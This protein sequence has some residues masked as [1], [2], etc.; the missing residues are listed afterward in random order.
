MHS[1]ETLIRRQGL[2]LFFRMK[3]N[4]PTGLGIDWF[5]E[6]LME[7]S[8][9]NEHF[10][11][12]SFRFI[13]ALPVL[14]TSKQI[15]EHLKAYFCNSNS[16]LPDWVSFIT[17]LIPTHGLYAGLVSKMVFLLAT[18]MASKF[19]AGSNLAEME[20]RI[21]K[22]RKA[23]LGFT[24]DILG[25][26][27]ITNAEGEQS[28]KDYL[29][30]ANHLS[31][32]SMCWQPNQRLDYENGRP[33]P[34]ANISIKLSSLDPNLNPTCPDESYAR[35]RSRL[36]P[37][38]EFAKKHNVF[39][40][41]DMEQRSLK[42][43]I[44]FVFKKA[45]MESVL[46]DYP[47]FGIAIQA[48]LKDTGDDLR[49]LLKW[50]QLRGTPVSI[51]LVKG[52][53]WDFET[54]N[55]NFQGW[56]CPVW[57]AKWQTDLAYE[58][59][60]AFLLRNHQYLHS[61][62]ASHNVRSVSN[63]IVRAR[64]LGLNAGSFE[65]QVLY[66]MGDSLGKALTEAG[67]RV[68]VYTPYGELLPGMAYLV[69]RLLEN[70]A[71]DSFLKASSIDHLAEEDLLMKPDESCVSMK[72]LSPQ[73]VPAIKDQSLYVFQNEPC[74]DFGL[75]GV[76]NQMREKVEK[77]LALQAIHVYPMINGKKIETINALDRFNPSHKSS[78]VSRVFLADK[79]IASD[80]LNCTSAVFKHWKTVPVSSRSKMLF[81]AA[82]I[83]RKSRMDLA[84]LQVIECGKSWHEADADVAEAVDFCE[85]YAKTAEIIFRPDVLEL[86]GEVN[87][88][89]AIPRGVAVV[90][91]PW[92]FPLAILVG[93]S[94]AALVTGNT[95]IIKPAE[96]S[97]AMALKW[98]EILLEA[99]FPPEVIGFLPGVGEEIGPF[100][101]DDIRTSI[102]A[103][104]G[105]R[106]V[107]LE[108][109]KN[110]AITL[111]SQHHVKK[112]IA[113]MGGKNAILV[114]E[115]ADPDEAISAIVQ[116]AMDFQGQK[117]SACSRVLVPKGMVDTFS[118]RLASAVAAR[119]IGPAE[120]PDCK[121][122]PVID[123]ESQLRIERF[124][125]EASK[126]TNLVYR[127]DVGGLKDHGYYVAPAIFS[128]AD[129]QS[130]LCQEEI[131]GP[132][133]AVIGYE[134]FGHGVEI[135]NQVPYALTAGLFSR[136][137]DRVELFQNQIEAGNV[138]INRKITGA[139]VH[140]QPFGGFKLSGLGSKA[141]GKDYL[142]QFVLQRTITENTIRRGFAPGAIS[143]SFLIES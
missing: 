50:A 29:E 76:R 85:Y 30:L 123:Q 107:G 102:V 59:H 48:Y 129:P 15:V 74:L 122:G 6:R 51:R 10:K 87:R 114:D 112:V 140:R 95:V 63:A 73:I 62:F 119:K 79:K 99:G 142:L 117:C 49:Q 27:T 77:A 54:I 82:E 116:S 9:S 65:F 111:P 143:R 94:A 34:I 78:Q 31:V 135:A 100:L 86:A 90:I 69:R 98:M 21:L 45:L 55:A 53:Y 11:I 137:P 61:A 47:F 126:K 72:D 133:L 138:Y 131:F 109:F 20:K 26:S 134:S 67:Y 92:N 91:A 89:S 125:Q 70:T 66:G 19:I 2:D 124:I 24:V 106:K 7:L 35:I 1:T 120:N 71:N 141:G 57:P 43:L 22:M 36:L 80:A 33:V 115:D 64:E 81:R 96:Q 130:G 17:S 41:F 128:G 18:R 23:G 121:I 46:K 132:V 68:R 4:R 103:F 93:M 105:S 40:Y 25:E 14:N 88:N 75:P 37:L 3:E 110:A 5:E 97:S 32:R 136:N 28:A 127:G 52:A 139:M 39:I 38:L 83:I 56:P 42:D 44:L 12:Q 113:E 58:E 8:T 84:A 16:G 60:S 108:I 118:N 101:V 13:D 104:T